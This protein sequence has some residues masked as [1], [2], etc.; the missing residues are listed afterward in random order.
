M[1]PKIFPELELVLKEENESRAFERHGLIDY[2]KTFQL[3]QLIA[4]LERL[5][6]YSARFTNPTIYPESE[7]KTKLFSSQFHQNILSVLIKPSTW[8]KLGQVNP[9]IDEQIQALHNHWIHR[10]YR[11]LASSTELSNILENKELEALRELATEAFHQTRR[12]KKTD[13]NNRAIYGQILIYLKPFVKGTEFQNEK[14]R[15][16]NDLLARL[17]VS[18]YSEEN[19]TD[20]VVHYVLRCLKN[21]NVADQLSQCRVGE[22]SGISEKQIQQF[23][24]KPHYS[25]MNPD[26][27]SKI[28]LQ[29]EEKG[30]PRQIASLRRLPI[31]T[32]NTKTFPTKNFRRRHH[33]FVVPSFLVGFIPR[34]KPW[35]AWVFPN[36]YFRYQYFRKKQGFLHLLKMGI[37]NSEHEIIQVDQL[38]VEKMRW[39]SKVANLEFQKISQEISATKSSRSRIFLKTWQTHIHEFKKQLDERITRDSEVL[40][41]ISL[42]IPAENCQE[43][44]PKSQTLL[45][46]NAS[47]V[48]V[49][50]LTKLDAKQRKV[51]DGFYQASS[52]QNLDSLTLNEMSALLKIARASFSETEE[53]FMLECRRYLDSRFFSAIAAYLISKAS[54]NWMREN[55]REKEHFLF[56][57]SD[58]FQLSR[59]DSLAKTLA[60]FI[61]PISEIFLKQLQMFC[62]NLVHDYSLGFLSPEKIADYH[63][64][65]SQLIRVAEQNPKSLGFILTV[66]TELKLI[67]NPHL[68]EAKCCAILEGIR[69]KRF[70]ASSLFWKKTLEKQNISPTNPSISA[71]A[72][73]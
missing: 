1:R 64:Y 51:L 2:L 58:F 34:F 5:K 30:S 67:N 7:G 61:S 31:F 11:S 20:D 27:Y 26:L 35:P 54:T 45:K 13:P 25:G 29:I 42:A 47:S 62:E 65:L 12:R 71:G 69:S 4:F 38:I 21:L 32:E 24:K 17:H 56:C 59:E 14:N 9:R 57:L 37:Q 41:S 40:H 55:P 53:F 66:F 68:L 8:I 18:S 60:E 10:M 6:F 28:I 63:A 43:I 19:S 49:K 46:M 3:S 73:K 15:V 44:A 36:R 16:L 50:S 70:S 52:T 72:T 23:L 48:N 33:L 22:E 39:A